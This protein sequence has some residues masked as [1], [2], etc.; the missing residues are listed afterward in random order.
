ME[1]VETQ[2]PTAQDKVVESQK[3]ITYE[4]NREMARDISLLTLE[5]SKWKYHVGQCEKGIIPLYDHKN[6]IQGLREKWAAEI[7]FQKIRWEK[8]QE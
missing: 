3:P 1:V 2:E 7:F 8:V 5:L 4:G 6:T